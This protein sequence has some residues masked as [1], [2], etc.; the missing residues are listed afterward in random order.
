MVEMSEI[1]ISKD[2]CIRYELFMGD[3]GRGPILDGHMVHQAQH[4]PFIFCV[5]GF[6]SIFF[7]HLLT[8][9]SSYQVLQLKGVVEG[10]GM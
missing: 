2:V 7:E 4:H 3:M 9:G 10:Y 8:F 5:S 6:V 1:G